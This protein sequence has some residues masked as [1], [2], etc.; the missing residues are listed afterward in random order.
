MT[1]EGTLLCTVRID[2]KKCSYC[3]D[4]VHSCPN[5]ALTWEGDCFQHNPELCTYCE[6]CLDL[7]NEEALEILEK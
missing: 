4:C 2:D 5:D 7:C 6:L 1:D 3:L